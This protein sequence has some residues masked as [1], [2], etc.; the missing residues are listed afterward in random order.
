EVCGVEV[1]LRRLFEAPSVRGLAEC[2][3]QT[4]RAEATLR[5]PALERVSRA[6]PLPLSFAQ[7]RLWFL[8]QLEPHSPAYNIPV[9]VRLS[10]SLNVAALEQSLGEVIRRHESLRTVF[11]KKNGEVVQVVSTG[12]VLN[13]PLIDLQ[14]LTDEEQSTEA[15]RLMEEAARLPFDLAR[16]L[17]LRACLVRLNSTEHF[18]LLTVHHIVSDGWSM[19]VLLREVTALYEAFSAARPSPLA[20]LSIQYADFAVWQR[21]WLKGEQ[22]E[23]QLA[24]WRRH[25]AGQ[26]PVL[27]LQGDRPRS[28]A[29]QRGGKETLI[30]SPALRDSLQQL[31]R[32]EGSTLYMIMLAAFYVLLARYSGQDDIVVGTDVANRNRAET[33]NLIGFFV[34]QLVLRADLSGNPRFCDFLKQVRE[35]ALM[36]YMHQDLPYEKVVA[37]LNPDRAESRNPLFQA[38]IVYQNVPRGKFELSG[39]GLVLTPMEVGAGT[40]VANFD[41]LL[42]LM[43]TNG[44]LQASFEYSADLFDPATIKRMLE[45]YGTLLGSIV[46]QPDDVLDQLEIL[47]PGERKA[48]DA[49]RHNRE[50]SKLKKFKS[51]KPKIHSLSQNALIET[52]CLSAAECLPLVLR[53]A[54]SNV[55]LAE[56]VGNNL[57]TIERHLLEH[58]AILFRGFNLN[59]QSKFEEFLAATSIELMH[60]RER[61]SPRTRLSHKVYTSTE[62]PADETIALHNE[63]TYVMNWPMKIWF[64]CLQAARQRGQTP[65]ADVRKVFQRID[66]KIRER[67][68]AQGWMLVRNF[69]DGL[70]LDW[71]DSFRLYSKS[72]VE[73][74][75]QGAQIACEWKAQDRLRTR[76]VRSAVARHPQTGEQVWFNHI[77]FW[78]VSSLRP[79]VRE[80][81]LAS[82]AE[83]ELPYNTYY[84]DGSSIENSVIEEI[85]EA[86][87]AEKVEFEWRDGDLLM[88]DNML[89]AHGRTPFVGPRRVMVAMGDVFTREP[90]SV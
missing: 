52:D 62:Y 72:E 67:F 31:S 86:Y 88:L 49:E 58:G 11:G 80:A 90:V 29:R 28:S 74:Y 89:V 32:R 64:Y 14:Y 81:M 44:G 10:G 65:L 15:K 42:S 19:A 69:G 23:T 17:L 55:H 61:S 12:Q 83:E 41:L 34:N 39:S 2:V 5:A 26:L 24:Y 56:W 66:P 87:E 63:L 48:Q 51:V 78:H 79:K 16:D 59:A 73:K 21:E 53:P 57:K 76:Q 13:V 25:L 1:G 8:D 47:T 70:S 45:N 7:Q 36:A 37:M 38:K 77:A 68:T 20:D 82:L 30:Y 40:G 22:L 54:V 3:E 75:C 85:R 27:A 71:R 60:Y 4:L 18:A 33:E 9:R 35:L 46:A 43:D 84:G 6:A 50:E